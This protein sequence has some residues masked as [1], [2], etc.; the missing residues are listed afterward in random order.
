MYSKAITFLFLLFFS[1]LYA[2]SITSISIPVNS[3]DAT[4]TPADSGVWTSSPLDINS[5]I[6]YWV[7]PSLSGNFVMHDHVYVSTYV[8]DP[9]RAVVTYKFDQ[10]VVVTQVNIYQHVRGITQ[11]EAKVGNSLDSLS[12][13]GTTFSNRGD[14]T[15]WIVF[16][17]WE[18]TTFSFNSNT[19]AGT[20]FQMIVRKTA[21]ENGYAAYRGLLTF[22]EP[23]PEPAS[24]CSIAIGLL[25]CMVIRYKK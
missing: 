9:S 20:Y 13:I 10:A 2:A 5:G 7:N 24:L 16:N 15:G 21:W 23:V 11:I 25:F 8:P 12:S 4:C 6:G 3:M 18:N 14:L 22:T 1:F 19:M 17:E